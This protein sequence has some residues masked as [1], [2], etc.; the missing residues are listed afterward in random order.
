MNGQESRMRLRILLITISVLVILLVCRVIF[1]SSRDD[2]EFNILER[3]SGTRRRGNIVDR[4]NRLFAISD[5]LV[6]ISGSPREIDKKKETAAFLSKTLDIEYERVYE[7]INSPKNFV[8][9]KRQVKP[10][11]AEKVKEKKIKGLYFTGEYKRFYPNNNLASHLLGFCNIDNR[12]VEGIEKSMDKYLLADIV[13]EDEENTISDK[14]FNIQLT[15]DHVI[16]AITERTLKESMETEMA[17]AASA[18]F[19]NGKT[20]EILAMANYPDFNPNRYSSYSQKI[21]RNTAI[22]SQFE[23]GSVIKIFSLASLLDSGLLSPYDTFICDGVHVDG[24]EQVNCTGVHGEIDMAG[25]IKYSCNDGTLQAASMIK[26]LNFYHYMKA[27]GFGVSTSI[28]VPGEQQGV[29]RRIDAW[30]GRSMLSIPIGQEISVNSLQIA[31]AAT[32]FLNKGTMIQPYVVK[33]IYNENNT[34]IRDFGR[35]E[36]RQV[37]DEKTAGLVLSGMRKSTEDGGT[38]DE[39]LIPGI[40]FNAKSGTAELFDPELQTYSPDDFT[41]SLLVTFPAESPK[42]IIYVVFHKPRGEIKW[43]GVIGARF[44]N[45][46]VGNL[47]GYLDIYQ[48]KYKVQS[49]QI[50]SESNISPAAGIRVMPDLLGLTGQDAIGYFSRTEIELRITGKGRIYKTVPAAGEPLKGKTTI[51]VYLR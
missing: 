51:I 50:Y 41:S 49:K 30:S 20:G 12:G 18:I 29:L 25:I 35:R 24:E 45:N 11:V 23:P 34:T 22:F 13:L 32:V 33:R 14:G 1:L 6:S 28:Q 31:R 8:W 43:G 4:N 47:T 27:F 21:F 37:V 10:D 46:L 19:L 48:Q 17:D 9:I 3:V 5:E 42:Y 26:P 16:Q 38:V 2:S 7:D 44:V 36:I 40:M 15:L 39:L